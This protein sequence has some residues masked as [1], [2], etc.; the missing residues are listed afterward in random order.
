M[1]IRYVVRYLMLRLL[2]RTCTSLVM[3][4]EGRALPSRTEM[5]L[6]RPTNALRMRR[7]WCSRLRSEV[8]IKKNLRCRCS[9]RLVLPSLVGHSMWE[10]SL[11]CIILVIV[12]RRLLVPKWLRP[13]LRS[14]SVCYRCRAPISVLC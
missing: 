10:T 1:A 13:R 7:R 6:V 5:R 14:V 12:F 2:I 9:L 3:V 11:V 4:T 8:E